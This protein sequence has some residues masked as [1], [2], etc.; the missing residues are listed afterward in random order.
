M[1]Q[2]PIDLAEGSGLPSGI[3]LRRPRV[4]DHAPVVAAI[5]EWWDMPGTSIHLLLPPLFFQHF[6][7]T[8]FVAEDADGIAAFLI[9]F[10][11][12]AQPGVAY[13]HFVGVRPDLRRAGLARTLYRTF[14]AEAATA[15]CH[16]VEAITGVPNRRSQAFH[17]ALGFEASGDSDVD[18][19]LAWRDYDGP[20]EHRVAFSRVL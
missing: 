3:T 20:G 11:S 10:H 19:V 4:A 1:L 15:G 13:I 17:A 6:S 7:D 9:G 16:R 2:P 12:H 18:G 5:P 14:F 8:S